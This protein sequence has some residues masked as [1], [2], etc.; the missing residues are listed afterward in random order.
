MALCTCGVTVVPP[1]CYVCMYVCMYVCTPP[2]D[3][4]H[5]PVPG[6]LEKPLAEI[7]PALSGRRKDGQPVWVVMHHLRFI[8]HVTTVYSRRDKLLS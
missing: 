3:I 6:V 4:C 1:S 7:P 8:N 5:V 2:I